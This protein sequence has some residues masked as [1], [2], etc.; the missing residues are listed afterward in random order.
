MKKLISLLMA[1]IMTFSLTACGNTD[2]NNNDAV[3][4]PK[5]EVVVIQA[6]YEN[7]PGEPIDLAMHEWARLLEEKSGGSMK[8]DLYPSSQLGSK[9]DIIDQMIAGDSVITLAD[10]AFYADRGVPDLGIVF[11]PYLFETWDEVWK[12]IESD[13]YAEQSDKLEEQGLKIIASNWIYGERHTLTTKP[14]RHVEDL[15][16]MKIRVPNNKIQIKGFEV[17]GAT[18]TP[19]ALGEVYTSLQQGTIDG[20]ENPLPVLY[21]GKFQEVAKNLTLDGH[22]KN[23]TTWVCGSDFFNSL[24]EEQQTLLIETCEEAGLFN[25]D[26]QAEVFDET[27]QKFKDDGIEIIEVDIKEFQDASASFYTLPEFSDWTPGLYDT[28]K[29][30]IK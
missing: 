7:N 6:G 2:E 18:A 13:W 30:V 1:G 20:L 25:N 16:G 26:L 14:V 22:V 5:D 21:N 8:M 27:L 11:A 3:S 17:L 4:A 12:L 23:F 29:A 19:M 28:V 9:N 10:G 15:K 24:T